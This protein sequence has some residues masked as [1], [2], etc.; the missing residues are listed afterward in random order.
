MNKQ[1]NGL[2]AT[3]L[4]KENAKLKAELEALKNKKKSGFSGWIVTAKNPKF[5]GSTRGFQF[6]K[7][8]AFI[9]DIEGMDIVIRELTSDFEYSA[10]RVEDF[11]EMPQGG[12]DIT[13]NLIDVVARPQMVV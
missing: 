10:T 3:D 8:K 11:A 7:G 1:D 4:E 9:P 12:E 5:N 13:R 6:R 2:Q